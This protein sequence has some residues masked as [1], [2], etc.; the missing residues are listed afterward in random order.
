MLRMQ[1]MWRDDDTTSR[2]VGLHAI[3]FYLQKQHQERV[4]LYTLR[5]E[6]RQDHSHVI[7][8]L[9]GCAQRMFQVNTRYAE[10]RDT[11]KEMTETVNS[12]TS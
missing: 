9:L 6:R 8:H 5:L 3:F 10:E 2:L 12:N 7:R 1:A 11:T 4:F